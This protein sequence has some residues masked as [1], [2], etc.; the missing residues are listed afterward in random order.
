M[1]DPE[2]QNQPLLAEVN[3]QAATAQGGRSSRAYKVAGLTLLASL[4]I[5]GQA[6]TI[7]F[8]L[9]QKSDVKSLREKINNLE[10]E[11]TKS[12]AVVVPVRMSMDALSNMMDVSVDEE[13]STKEPEQTVTQQDTV[14]QLEA[15]GMKPVQLPG[16]WPA[17][18]ERGLYREQQCFV[19]HCWCV[20]PAD[21]QPLP[22]SL[23]KGPAHCGASFPGSLT[24]L[25]TLP[26]AV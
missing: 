5:V 13:A 4:L 24:H 9:S 21:G 23:T 20:N 18:D 8:V 6:L 25:L 3:Q 17:C 10:S 11:L 15:A 7:Y 14:C 2:I 16:F 1:S 19:R 22:G 26:D 12:R